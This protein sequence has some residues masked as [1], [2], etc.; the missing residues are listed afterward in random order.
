LKNADVPSSRLFDEVSGYWTEIAQT[1]HTDKQLHFVKGNLEAEGMVLDLGC[2]SGRHLILLCQAGCN[3]VGLDFSRCLLQTAKAK[4][5]Q[6]GVEA[7]LV[8]GD[9][10]FL[11]FRPAVFAAV[12]SLDASFGYLPSEAAD[13]QSLGE[14]ARVLAAGGVLVLDVFNGEK[15]KRMQ[16]KRVGFGL[17]ERI[18]G[19]SPQLAGKLLGFVG[20]REYPSFFL[21]QKRAVSRK[22]DLMLELWFFQNKKTGQVTMAKHVV[23]LYSV[24]QLQQLIKKTGLHVTHV[25]GGYNGE[26]YG[27]WSSRLI[28]MAEN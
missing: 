4:A 3:M 8:L 7:V 16:A 19:L 15:I 26:S 28:V 12:V 20:W 10:Q 9:M 24:S 14:V 6:A 27:D 1:H 2:G 11:P 25:F 13:G 23:R 22:G 17:W 21:Q 18:G 5:A